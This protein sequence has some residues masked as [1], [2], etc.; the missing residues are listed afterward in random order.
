MAPADPEALARIAKRSGPFAAGRNG[1][2]VWDDLLIAEPQLRTLEEEARRGRFGEKHMPALPDRCNAEV[3]GETST[4]STAAGTGRRLP[5]PALPPSIAP[6]DF[7][8][9]RL[10][11][12][13]LWHVAFWGLTA[14]AALAFLVV[15]AAW[16]GLAGLAAAVVI[17][18]VGYEG[19]RRWNR[20]R[21]LRQFPE[22]VE[23]PFTWRQDRLT[24]H[25]ITP[26]TVATTP[27][28]A[29]QRKR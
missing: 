29:R 2:G 11:Q 10:R 19:L 18:L 8:A 3:P 16:S 21:W 15:S 13:K 6:A 26:A 24:D 5:V 12:R 23:I 22:L 7:Q 17:M 25:H 1:D 28:Q 4:G 14:L 9:F 27:T 20:E